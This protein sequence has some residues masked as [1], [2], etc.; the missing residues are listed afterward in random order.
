[1]CVYHVRCLCL[2]V[3]YC[4]FNFYSNC[5]IGESKLMIYFSRL[6]HMNLLCFKYQ[7]KSKIDFEI[8]SRKYH[9]N[10]VYEFTNRK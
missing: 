3:K 1:M 6:T 5:T 8:S 9:A 7:M 10:F 2:C 4:L